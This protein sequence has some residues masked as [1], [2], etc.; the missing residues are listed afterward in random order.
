MLT[1]AGDV[2]LGRS[3]QNGLI[4]DTSLSDVTTGLTY[5]GFDEMETCQATVA[6]SVVALWSYS[7][8]KLGRITEKVETQE[9]RYLG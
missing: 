1:G 2:T 6:G 9:C 3:T 4:A 7:R 5:N 8:D